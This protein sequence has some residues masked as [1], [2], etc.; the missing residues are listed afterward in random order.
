MYTLADFNDRIGYNLILTFT[1]YDVIFEEIHKYVGDSKIA[2]VMHNIAGVL[3][4]KQHLNKSLIN[5]EV[6]KQ[7]FHALQDEFGLKELDLHLS[8]LRQEL[9]RQNNG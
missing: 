7:M 1:L 8:E 5:I 3:N 2:E 6:R 4:D 9:E